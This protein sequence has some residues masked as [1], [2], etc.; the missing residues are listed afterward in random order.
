LNFPYD[1]TYIDV[2]SDTNTTIQWTASNIPYSGGGAAASDVDSTSVEILKDRQ[3]DVKAYGATGGGLINDTTAILAAQAYAAMIGAELVFPAGQYLITPGAISLPANITWRGIGDARLITKETAIYNIMVI[4]H[5]DNIKLINI[6]FDQTGD[7]ALTPIPATG[8]HILHFN[9]FKSA[10][11]KECRFWGYGIT[12][13]LTQPTDGFGESVIAEGNSAVWSKKVN[14]IYDVSVF[15]LDALNVICDNNKVVAVDAGVATEWMPETAFE[16]HMPSGHVFNNEATRVKNGVI[17]VCAPMLYAKYPDYLIY[18]GVQ[19]AHNRFLKCLAAVSAWGPN[20][21]AGVVTRN[22][23][24][25]ENYHNAHIGGNGGGLASA[26]KPTTSIE[27]RNGSQNG[28]YFRNVKIAD[29]ICEYTKTRYISGTSQITFTTTTITTTGDNFRDFAVGD[30]IRVTGSVSNNLSAKRIT[31][32]APKVLTFA[33]ATWTAGADASAITI[34]IDIDN[35]LGGGIAY[36]YCGAIKGITAN[37]IEDIDIVGNSIISWPFAAFSFHGT[38][39]QH[40]RIRIFNNRI[41]DS[42]YI[43][44]STATYLGIFNFNNCADVEVK[45]NKCI[46]G[47]VTNKT[48]L[49]TLYLGAT[50]L[51]GLS[52]IDN[53]TSTLTATE[54]AYETNDTILKTMITDSPAFI[55]LGCK[56]NIIPS[57]VGTP[58]PGTTG[59]LSVTMDGALKTITPTGACTLN[60]TG[61]KVGQKCEI[62]ITTSGTTSYAVTFGTNFL[63]TGAINTGT[64]TA[65]TFLV[66]FVYNGTRWLEVSRTI[67]M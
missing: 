24:I 11:V 22:L 61:G 31:A 54:A 25:N 58:I 49:K 33:A 35:W 8:C 36:T 19:I 30:Y 3:I 10:M 23:I 44:P 16:L 67:A 48:P 45:S 64:V 38:T 34:Q 18:G 20:T 12:L 46:K 13:M 14:A 62:V 39:L 66:S 1:V 41:V 43:Q 59:T 15:N 55:A 9:N 50:A 47:G 40:K 57:G 42:A 63:S 26:F 56:P 52:F 17:H 53:D 37:G 6:G 4:C 2:C 7:S 27:L 5:N 28:G 65:K 21:I 60:A 51:T 32:V 29:N